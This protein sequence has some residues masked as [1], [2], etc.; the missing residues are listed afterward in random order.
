MPTASPSASIAALGP[1]PP[2]ASGASVRRAVD[3]WLAANAGETRRRLARRLADALAAA[4]GRPRHLRTLHRYIGGGIEGV[5]HDVVHALEG[6][7]GL[8]RDGIEAE[9]VTFTEVKPLV[10]A[11]LTAGP[12]RTKRALALALAER[13]RTDGAPM[14]VDH[15]QMLLGGR[16]PAVRRRVVEELRAMVGEPAAE[17][18]AFEARAFE[19]ASAL[20]PLLEELRRRRG[21]LS[22]RRVAALLAPYVRAHGL[23]MGEGQLERAVNGRTKHVRRAVR[24]ALE[25][26]L[27]ADDG[28]AEPRVDTR[29]PLAREA[30]RPSALAR[31]GPA[32]RERGRAA[33]ER[34]VTERAAPRARVDRRA[35]PTPSPTPLRPS[36]PDP[37]LEALVREHMPLVRKIARSFRRYGLDQEDLVQEGTVGLVIAI[38][39]F[40]ASRGAKLSTYAGFW[41]RAMLFDF[42]FKQKGLV[43]FG[44]RRHSRLFFGLR[45][46]EARLESQLG[47]RDRVEEELAREFRV[48][49]DEVR[50]SLSRLWG[51]DVSLDAPGPSE[52]SRLELL[53]H[54][55]EDPEEAFARAE[56]IARLRQGLRDLDARLDARDKAILERRWMAD[57]EATLAELGAE[58]GVSR[59][60]IRQVERR[61]AD[62][63]RVA[64]AP[65]AYADAG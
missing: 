21:P 4:D 14:T 35:A 24:I 29:A 39:R 25:A 47:D 37:Q 40:D 2:R 1:A 61:L 65:V 27:A 45:R 52:R 46:A 36:A 34:R 50:L 43:R 17:S 55:G 9:F 58:W 5:P 23:E 38:R 15:L 33:R 19:A 63:L 12:R 57:A 3:R 60:R 8:E 28:P 48:G 6:L 18:G 44:H 62:E 41:I 53:E 49:V 26:L 30:P 13:L 10:E 16:Q 59:E 51:R 22:G 64:L 54:V 56:R 32:R 20:T 42:V 7:I 11:W 31:R